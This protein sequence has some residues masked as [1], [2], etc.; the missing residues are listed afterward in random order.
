[1]PTH[2]WWDSRTYQDYYTDVGKHAL[3]TPD[4]ELQLLKRYRSCNLCKR[5]IPQFITLE[6][7]PSCSEPIPRKAARIYTCKCCEHKFDIQAVPS[8]CPRCGNARDYAAKHRL[9]EAN[10]R[11]V[12][13]RARTMTANPEYLNR[14]ISAG[15]VGLMLA[16][17]KYNLKRGTRFLT[18]A[19]W[20]IRKEMLDE[21]RNTNLVHIPTHRQK[22]IMQAQKHGQYSCKHCGITTDH[23][24]YEAYLPPCRGVGKRHEFSQ[25]Q[26]DAATATTVL[27][28]NTSDVTLPASPENVESNII[29]NDMALTLRAVLREL[30]VRARD[31]YIVMGY[32]NAASGDRKAEEPKNL[33]Q[34]S[35]ITGV[36]PERVRQIKE[37]VLG[38]FK[39]ELTKRKFQACV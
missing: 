35:A 17:D 21:I 26:Y 39:K 37:Q 7:C 23:P 5:S 1:M 34:L 30:N 19:D 2:N 4:E 18:Y 15:N 20:W 22:S 38:V 9:V 13:R 11:F 3:L 31:R 36:T 32:F 16:V 6:R 8:H 33:W 29:D 10:L 27:S 14:L 25:P 24:D 28:V 12:V